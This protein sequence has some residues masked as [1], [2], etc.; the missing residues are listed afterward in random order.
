MESLG[1][2]RMDGMKLRALM[3]VPSRRPVLRSPKPFGASWLLSVLLVLLLVGCRTGSASEGERK[4]G[5]SGPKEVREVELVAVEQRPIEQAVEVSGTLAPDEEVTVAVKVAGRLQSI[6]VDLASPVKRDQPIAEVEP[7]DYRLRVEQAAAA[8]A[9]ARAQL[10]LPPRGGEQGFDAENTAIVR[11]AQATMKHA[12]AELARAKVMEK[13]G[14]TSQASLEALEAQAIRSET[15]VQA[16]LE[17]VR[18]RQATMRQRQS[19]LSLAQ[20]QLQDTVLRAPLDGIVQARLATAGEYL[21]VGAPVVRIVRI[22]PLRLRVAIPER[23]AHSVAAGQS[24]QVRVDGTPQSYTGLVSRI[25]PSLEQESRSLLV[26]ADV[27]NPGALR[28]GSFAHARI[29]VG[30]EPVLALP[31]TAVVVFAG[32]Y[33]VLLVQEG[34]A[35]E[36]VVTPGRTEGEWTEIVSGLKRGEQ[37]VVKPGSLQQGQPVRVKLGA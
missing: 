2:A 36:K 35:V 23:E 8:L 24:V 26:E 19:E 14:L 16:A 6:A 25:A 12:Q 29:V 27:K 7:A 32:L 21:A 15:A 34:K 5:Q 28:P 22:D 17:E 10:G 3:Q 13:S 11:Q 1:L 37:V 4:R 20:K 30:T 31:K 9:Q 18:I 33:K